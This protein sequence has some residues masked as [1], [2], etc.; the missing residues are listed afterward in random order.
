MLF[1]TGNLVLLNLFL[2]LLL[3]NFSSADIEKSARREVI[4]NENRALWAI[5]AVQSKDMEKADKALLKKWYLYKLHK[6]L[7]MSYNEYT[8][9]EE[10]RAKK[11]VSRKVQQ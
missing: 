8:E 4:K 6:E 10:K 5:I 3:S 2:A 11:E 1:V 7:D 9:D